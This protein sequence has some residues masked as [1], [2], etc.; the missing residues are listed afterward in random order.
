MTAV[1]DDAVKLI[2]KSNVF[3][4][5]DLDAGYWQVKLH[6]GLKD[7]TAF[8]IPN[9]KMHW[10]VMPM[11]ILNAHAFF[12]SMTMDMKREWDAKFKE[13]PAAA[14]NFLKEI[15][16]DVTP[17]PNKMSPQGVNWV[18]QLA[19]LLTEG[20]IRKAIKDSAPGS[21]V[22][23]DDLMLHDS[24]ELSLM[25]YFVSILKVLVHYQVTINLRK[26]RFLPKRAEFVGVDVLPN[27][28]SPAESKYSGI[29]KLGNPK[30][31]SDIR[32]II[33][34]FGFYQQWIPHYEDEIAIFR[35]ILLT[36]GEK[37]S[38]EEEEAKVEREWDEKCDEVL[39]N[40]K[41]YIKEGPVL[42]RPDPN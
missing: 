19:E 18:Q 12:V 39:T 17:I 27:G 11:G 38:E 41:K 23:V 6:E 1:C 22:I 13:D 9:G 42:K 33:G 30:N 40:L 35:D 7:K 36:K 8:F 28:N 10:L 14:I 34:I 29:D 15:V 25:A 24:N 32:A 31:F 3:I 21:A 2:G 37:L 20:N 16:K 5:L 26:G 4:T